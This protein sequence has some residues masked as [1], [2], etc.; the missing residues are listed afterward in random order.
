MQ[1]VAGGITGGT[2]CRDCLACADGLACAHIQRRTM[3]IYG[4]QTV[5]MGNDDVI[6]GRT[7]IG[8]RGHTP[9][10]CRYDRSSV[11][12]SDINAL[13][14][15][16]RACCRLGTIAK[17]TGNSPTAGTGPYEAGGSSITVTGLSVGCCRRHCTRLWTV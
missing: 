7:T 3:H 6:A 17:S 15:G 10:G 1:V 14:V 9:G 4:R 16:R 13:V 11:G 12:C 5:S 2:H 8:R